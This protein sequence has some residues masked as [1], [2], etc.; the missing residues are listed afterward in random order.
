MRAASF[1]TF[2]VF[3]FL[4]ALIT[5]GGL[6]VAVGQESKQVAKEEG[7]S[8]YTVESGD[9]PE[10]IKVGDT[11]RFYRSCSKAEGNSLKVEVTGGLTITEFRSIKIVKGKVVVTDTVDKVYS[12]TAEKKGKAS[13]TIR[14]TLDGMPGLPEKYEIEV[15][16]KE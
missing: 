8:V 6:S 10:K 9:L 15:I 5:A 16:E 3:L 4:V 1:G 12:V 13:V 7:P 14:R 11:I 2:V